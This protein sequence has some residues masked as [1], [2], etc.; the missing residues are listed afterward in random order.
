M[1]TMSACCLTV[2]AKSPGL[3]IAKL[4]SQR[5]LPRIFADH[6]G[7]GKINHREHAGTRRKLREM[8]PGNVSEFLELSHWRGFSPCHLG[9]SIKPKMRALRMAGKVVGVVRSARQKDRRVLRSRGAA[10]DQDDRVQ[11]H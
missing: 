8:L 3:A 11:L 4:L 1:R 10:R 6:R 2:Y 5:C 7:S 9:H